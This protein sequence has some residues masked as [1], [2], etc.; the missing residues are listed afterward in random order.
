MNKFEKHIQKIDFII[1]QRLYKVLNNREF[2]E[3]ISLINNLWGLKS[4]SRTKVKDF[5][6]SNNYVYRD[7]LDG[8]TNSGIFVFRDTKYDDLDVASTRSRTSHFSHYTALYIH[9]LTIQF[10]K[11]IYLTLERP[12]YKPAKYNMILQDILDMVFSKAPRATTNKRIYKRF[13]VN[14]INGQSQHN[15][16]IVPFREVYTVSDVERTLIDIAVRPFYS[17]GV[18]Q[19][20]EAFKNAQELIN[21]DKLFHYY[22]KMHFGYP[23]HQVIGFYLEK[24][25]YKES[26]YAKFLEIPM[27]LDFYLTYNMVNKNY[28]KKWKLFIPKGL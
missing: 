23:Y 20:L 22:S 28:C 12:T 2:E 10:P 25:G 3:L 26:D 1:N 19:V 16:G 8:D 14:F 13:T 9:G 15:M 6:F 17:G 4:Y 18:V 21:A 27:N 5:L 24:A 7:S 11:Q